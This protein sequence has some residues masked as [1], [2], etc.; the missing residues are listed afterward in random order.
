M[1]TTFYF[2]LTG[3]PPIL[4]TFSSFWTGTSQAFRSKMT[5]AKSNTTIG[6]GNIID[7]AAGGNTKALDMQFIS[8]PLWGNQSITGT[9]S[10]QLMVREY[11][12]NDNVN[13]IVSSVY[14]IDNKGTTIRGTG[15]A[16]GIYGGINEFVN[17]ATHRN[18]KIFGGQTLTTVNALDGDRICL[19][20]G[21]NVVA[22]G[23]TSPQASA[24][25]GSNATD[26][27]AN[28]E[29]QTSDGAAWF[30]FNN[31]N[32]RFKDTMNCPINS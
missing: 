17:N 10:G 15:L 19:E 5:T 31:L 30:S 13:A 3:R 22:G 9:V 1:P 8:D 23:G 25:W 11:N 21:Y 29:T 16:S 12:V 14:V 26:L 27:P 32:L 6:V 28:D 7:I 20:I 4:Q 2:P 18:A 24:K